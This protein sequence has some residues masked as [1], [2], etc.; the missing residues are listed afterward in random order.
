MIEST[1]IVA[2]VH[3]LG[4]F[5]NKL[6]LMLLF[7]IICAIGVYFFANPLL[8]CITQPLNAKTLYF[9]TPVEGF[10][11]KVK[12]ALYGGLVVAFPFLAYN[13]VTLCTMHREPKFRIKMALQIVPFASLALVGGILF[14]YWFIL[15]TTVRFLLDCGK[16]FMVPMLS[17]NDYLSFATFL[18]LMIGCVFE[19]PLVLVALS[20]FGVIQSQMLMKQ[21]GVAVFTIFCVLA[22]LTPTPDA[23]TLTAIALPVIL[24]Y[25]LSI[26]WIWLL[27]RNAFA[28]QQKGNDHEPSQ[29][30]GDD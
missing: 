25:E 11:V 17:G 26:W 13:V 2:A 14:G 12:I 22:V 21:R 6:I 23:I 24:L 5:R 20:R 30:S 9:M 16:G 15:P 29:L 18:L 4:K 10:M 19:L 28:K 7:P 3:W 8:N 1:Q 27:E